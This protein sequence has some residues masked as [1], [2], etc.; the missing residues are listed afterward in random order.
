MADKNLME[1][2]RNTALIARKAGAKDARVFLS[3][4]RNVTLEWRDGKIDRIRESTSQGLSIDLYVEGRYSSNS[5]S[6]LRT[7]AIEEY[8]KTAVATTRYLAV[9]EHR[10]LPDPSRY[11]GMTTENL[12]RSDPTVSGIKPEERMAQARQLEEA[13]RAGDKKNKIVSVTSWVSDTSSITVGFAT[14]GLEATEAGTSFSRGAEASVRDTK[15]R[16]PSGVDYG[17]TRFQSDLPGI[18]DLGKGSLRRAMEQLGSRQVKTDVYQVVIENRVVP[19]FVRHL[20]SPLSGSSIQQ[21]RSFL[22]DKLEKEVGSKLLTIKSDPH[23][24][25]GLAST[26]WDGEGMAT[27][28]R[29]VFDKGVLK[30]FFLDTYYASKL[31]VDPTTSSKS[32]LIWKPGN[33][34]VKEMIK[35]MTRGIYITSFLGGNSNS[36]TGDFSLG[37][38]G[39]F[40]ENGKIIHPV[41]E[42]N[43]AGNHLEFW[44]NLAEVGNDPWSHSSN[45]APSLMFKDVQCSGA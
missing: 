36:T 23:L 31:G 26:A 25:R 33:R 30:T 34:S 8:V 28:R 6:D 44:I 37:I 20:L 24:K 4:S 10:K 5:T 32:N 17:S 9:D 19:T 1:M 15:D 29:P 21:K 35:G 27:V 7:E 2:A 43:M 39:H 18:D 42:M 16:K 38:K 22:E 45:R 11:K 14:N 41:S 12:E 13:V 40:V 3:R